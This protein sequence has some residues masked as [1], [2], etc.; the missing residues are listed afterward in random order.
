ML[1]HALLGGLVVVGVDDQARVG[2]GFLGVPRQPQLDN[3]KGA[4]QGK[5]SW[6]DGQDNIGYRGPMPP[7][8]HGTHRYYFKVYALDKPV[9]AAAAADKE[10]LL[11]EMKGHVLA[12]GVLMGT[13]KR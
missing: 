2:A 12:E 3:P 11:R 4:V 10:S 7:V 5:N 1:E 9:S 13:Y 8:G 6:P